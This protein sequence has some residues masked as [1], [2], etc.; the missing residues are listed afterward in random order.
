ME[1]GR[2]SSFS[3]SDCFDPNA[4]VIISYHSYNHKI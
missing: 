3:S 1:I 2:D 4:V